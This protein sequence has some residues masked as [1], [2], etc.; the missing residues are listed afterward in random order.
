MRIARILHGRDNADV[1]LSSRH[2]AIQIRWHAVDQR[3]VETNDAPV[4][5]AVNRIAVDVRNPSD[6]HQAATA[7]ARSNR[8]RML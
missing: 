3:C 7:G 8:R 6:F 1:Q 2:A 5:R 4:D